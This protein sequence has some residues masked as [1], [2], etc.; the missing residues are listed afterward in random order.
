MVLAAGKGERMLPLT[1]STPKP[2]LEA[3]GKS[4]IHHQVAKLA[5]AGFTD[6]VVNHA[7][8]GE[9]VE[10]AL[11]DGSALGVAITWSREDEP[12]ETAGGIIQALPLLEEDGK[13]ESFVSVNAD[14]FT[15]FPF[16]TLA[17]LDG[18]GLQAHLVL[19]DNPG[20]H[21]GGDFVLEDGKV[22]EAH[23][24]EDK[25]TYSGIAVYHPS[26][27][28]G[29]APGR[30]PVVPLLKQA[31]AQGR[32]SGEYYD[33]RWFDIGTPERLQELDALLRKQQAD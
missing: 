11:G 24:G 19:V 10:A 13:V 32:V 12:L 14:I 16:G 20:H 7:W 30:R 17:S 26:L 8:L 28:A 31:M 18:V 29:I 5:A 4:L 3:G 21:P 27:F 6:L 33:G 2:L 25:L 1:L 23:G 9:Q 22:R 15:D